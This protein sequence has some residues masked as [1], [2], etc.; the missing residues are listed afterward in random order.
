MTGPG[1]GAPSAPG[2]RQRVR[3]PNDV[4]GLATAAAALAVL[5]L[6]AVQAP[7]AV[8][9]VVGVVPAVAG[10]PLRTVFSVAS[11]VA[12]LALLGVLLT[13]AVDAARHRRTAL[14]HALVALVL[15]LVTGAAAE[16]LGD[17]VGGALAVVLTG[18][19][20]DAALVPVVAAVAFLVGA[21]LQRRRRWGQPAR[22]AVL[23]ALVS[24]VALG[25]LT[26]AGAFAGV[27]LGAVAGLTVRVAAGVPPARPADD[28]V[29]AEL[30]RAGVHVGALRVAEQ[31][32]GFLRFTAADATG[33]VTITVVDPDGRGVPFV[34]RAGRALRFRTSVVGRPSL[35][36]RGGLERQAS[37]AALAAAAGVAVPRVLALLSVGPALVLAERP[38][39]GTPLPAAGEC[40][41]QGLAAAFAAL[42]RLHDVGLAHGSLAPDCVVVL[43][44]GEAGFRD[45]RSAQP[46][47]GD[48]Q[49]DLD[50]V[51]LLVGGATVVGAGPAASALRAEYTAGSAAPRLTA[52]L[53]PV[54]L[55]PAVRR[56]VRGA[57]V[58]ADL[59]KELAQ[60]DGTTVAA[61][62]LE[63]FSVRAILTVAAS[64]V[65]ALLLASQL[66]QVSIVESLRRAEVP[67]LLAA[68]GGSAVTYVGAALVLVAFV[69]TALSLGRTTQVQ[70]A[71]AWLTLVTPPTV[72]HVG[73]NIRYLQR[74]GLTVTGAAASVAVSQLATVAVTVAILLVV[75]WASGVS[76]SRL[77]LVPSSDVLLVV[78]GAVV[79]VGL[80]I[81]VAPVRRMLG[82]RLEPLVRQS[83]PQLLAAVSE[84]CRL[85]TALGGILLQNAGYVLALDASLRAFDVSVALP[86]VIG[87][88]LV[89]ST[90]GSVAPTPGGL[91]AVEAAL[92]GG[93]T[94]TG[95][96]VS[97][98]LAVVLA[99]RTATFWLPAPVGWLAFVRLQRRHLV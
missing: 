80:L 67:W 82:R 46:A 81:A 94:A 54:A 53:Q 96:P 38:L 34:R 44:D 71:T 30:A 45:L 73:L 5:V 43:S 25:N 7:E 59:R 69:P 32:A 65:A 4:A 40:A 8:G 60:P 33:D 9:A 58:L 16:R 23:G 42:R 50:A 49:R 37:S 70:L 19:R 84:P 52:L 89:A 13:V 68:V 41:E 36:Q 35:T 56:S 98:A 62:R 27:L 64:T 29:R 20:D 2:L 6:A 63:R 79:V 95:V 91:G 77:S 3:R 90:V 87:V 14:L 88:Y 61:P 74:A 17:A 22:W 85:L 47:A 21:D 57:E 11:A 76:T 93:L 24:A 15:G 99:F 31:T 92:I 10:D 18:P 72:G 48:L 83:L 66:S 86:T 12:S 55:P 75:A 51:A 97:A 39:T 78:L 26:V 28:V 1:E